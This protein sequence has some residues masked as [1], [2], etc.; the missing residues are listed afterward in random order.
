[1]ATPTTTD[2]ARIGQYV[3]RLRHARSLTLTQ[4]AG[5]SDLSQPFLSQLERGQARPSMASLGRIAR[6]LGSSQL[7][8]LS[9]AA[10]LTAEPT[11]PVPGLVRAD[12]GDQG[13]YGLGTARLLVSGDRPFYPMLVESSNVDAGGYHRHAEDEFLHVLGG[14]CRV[15][16]DD[17][18]THELG[19]GDSLYYAGGTSHRW[20]SPDGAAYR[21]FVVKQHL[22]VTGSAPELGPDDPS[23]RTEA[24]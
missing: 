5:L 20:S 11:V 15:D 2:D 16:L 19:P 14:R 17:Q 8:I 1:M 7:E 9:G 10:S 24:T 3:R 18:G 22:T 13:P 21:V 12:E 4:L 6:A 23:P